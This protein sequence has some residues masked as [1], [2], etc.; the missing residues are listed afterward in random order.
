MPAAA[1]ALQPDS[2]MLVMVLLTIALPMTKVAYVGVGVLL[3]QL[4]TLLGAGAID[5]T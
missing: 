2:A 4:I 3:H 1:H 5:R